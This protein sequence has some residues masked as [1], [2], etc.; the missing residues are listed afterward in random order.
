M[1]RK[2]ITECS[3]FGLFVGFSGGARG[4]NAVVWTIILLQK[5][6]PTFIRSGKVYTFNWYQVVHLNPT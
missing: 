4:Y 1:S 5:Y 6:E 3:I 2:T